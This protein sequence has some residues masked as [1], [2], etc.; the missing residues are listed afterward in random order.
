MNYKG[1]FTI[2]VYATGPFLCV[3]GLDA[4]RSDALFHEHLP[5]IAWSGNWWLATFCKAFKEG[6]KIP[7][8]TIRLALYRLHGNQYSAIT[9]A[10]AVCI[11]TSRSPELVRQHAHGR[12][13]RITFTAAPGY[14]R[15]EL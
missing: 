15:W 3:T 13:P 5:P 11:E 14:R 12:T 6:A 8:L 7:S 1:V 9:G 4:T 10:G 2:A